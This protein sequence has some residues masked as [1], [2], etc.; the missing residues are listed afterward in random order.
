M[1]CNAAPRRGGGV[2]KSLMLRD[3]IRLRIPFFLLFILTCI[4]FPG[5]QYLGGYQIEAVLYCVEI[6]V[7]VVLIIV[8]IDYGIYKSKHR[9]LCERFENMST[10]ETGSKLNDTIIERDYE[11]IIERLYWIEKESA[12]SMEAKY[13]E[14][15]EYFTMWVHQIK[16]PISAL[17]LLFDDTEM[18]SG[19]KSAMKQEIFKV[20]QYAGMVD[21]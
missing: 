7:F 2:M 3:Y 6:E 18:D 13:L 20:E 9:K 21:R 8:L 4:L 16:T 1:G 5:V 15:I 11:Q 10:F 17:S 14:Q 19:A 12:D